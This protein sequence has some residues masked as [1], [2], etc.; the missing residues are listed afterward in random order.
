MGTD[1][2]KSEAPTGKGEEEKRDLERDGQAIKNDEEGSP[3]DEVGQ[4]EGQ[5]AISVEAP[6]PRPKN[7]KRRPT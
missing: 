1:E 6:T 2:D 7:A 5:D 4:N 3:V